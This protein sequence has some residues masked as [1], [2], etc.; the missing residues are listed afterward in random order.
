MDCGQLIEDWILYDNTLAKKLMP[1]RKIAIKNYLFNS[2]D[3]Y[4]RDERAKKQE[5]KFLAEKGGVEGLKKSY[6]KFL[7]RWGKQHPDDKDRISIEKYLSFLSKK[8]SQRGIRK[9]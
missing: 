9:S 7:K 4:T 2:I 3:S 1:I 6:K 5:E 8:L